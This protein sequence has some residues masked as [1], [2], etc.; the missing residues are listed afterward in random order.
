MKKLLMLVLVTVLVSSLLLAACPA[1]ETPT[2]PT[3]P[4]TPTA[5]A[6][7][8]EPE[9]E[10]E[11]KFAPTTEKPLE[12]NFSYHAPVPASMT[13]G[14][15]IPWSNDLE[16]ACGGLV[17]IVH[18]AGGSLLASNDAY[19]GV[20]SGMCD[21]AQVATEEFAGR[22]PRSDLTYLPLIWPNTEICGVV[23]H[24]FLDKYCV[25]TELKD[26]KLMI[27]LPLHP[28]QL[29]SNHE[30]KVMEDF[31]GLKVRCI[32]DTDSAWESAL[33]ATPVRV[34][35]ADMFSALDTG[36]IDAT[37]FTFGGALAFGI[38]DVT[39]HRI[40]CDIS[41]SSFQIHMNKQTYQKLPDDLKKIFD[42]FSTAEASRKYAVIH[43]DMQEAYVKSLELGDSRRGNPPIYVIPPEER[44]RWKVTI[45]PVV[46]DFVVEL[47]EKGLPGQ[48]MF[49]YIKERIEVYS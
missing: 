25:D 9:P 27:T 20:L 26:I 14:I 18:H 35:T 21:L 34:T 43:M 12:L 37:F 48:E 23:Y 47:E 32:G 7:E 31:D 24:E 5:P 36:L 30:I 45:Q 2:A 17:K 16:A 13:Q 41:I 22:F 8:P 49:D 39:K 28:T 15:I 42:E 40:E 46:D 3:T 6:P 38:L 11:D 4:E 1:T 10:P 33:G 29:H 19:D 44:E